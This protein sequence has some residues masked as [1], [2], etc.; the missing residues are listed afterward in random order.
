MTDQLAENIIENL[1]ALA[2]KLA[3]SEH[4]RNQ[5]TVQARHQRPAW[6]L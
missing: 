4:E 1:Q 3:A 5:D 2:D 6:L